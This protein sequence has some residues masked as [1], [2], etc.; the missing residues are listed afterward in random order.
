MQLGVSKNGMVLD[1]SRSSS[2]SRWNKLNWSVWTSCFAG[3][4]KRATGT[5]VPVEKRTGK[6]GRLRAEEQLLQLPQLG[7]S[8]V[9]AAP[10]AARRCSRTFSPIGFI[11]DGLIANSR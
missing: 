4:R 6:D 9:Q 7:G 11:D 5:N 1:I 8:E 10:G 3:A 2:R